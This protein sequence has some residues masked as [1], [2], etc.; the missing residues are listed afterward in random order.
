MAKVK[1]YNSDLESYIRDVEAQVKVDHGG[2][3]P[4]HLNLTIRNYAYALATRD[5]YLKKILKDGPIKT[6]T[7]TAGFNVEKQHPLCSLLYQQEILCLNYA[8]AL[9]GTAAKAAQKP[10]DPDKSKSTDKLNEFL[11]ATRG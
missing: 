2:R 8:K 5:M 6:E 1:G 3:I 11:E 10:E 9:G 7:N 4:E